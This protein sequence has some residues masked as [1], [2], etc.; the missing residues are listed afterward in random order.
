MKS[1]T[2]PTY[3]EHDGRRDEAEDDD[4]V[5]RH[6]DESRVVD[7]AHLLGASLVGQEQAQHQL[8]TLVSV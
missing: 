2:P 8:Q 1:A 3:D 7:L 6:P 4:V 5:G